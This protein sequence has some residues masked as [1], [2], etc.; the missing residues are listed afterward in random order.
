MMKSVR[1]LLASL[2]LALGAPSMPGAA[3]A[4][5][6]TQGGYEILIK[7]LTGTQFTLSVVPADTI[8]A[9]K[10]QITDRQGIPV[11]QQR[12]IF[13]GVQLEDQRTLSD[14]NVQKDATLYLVLRL[15]GG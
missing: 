8:A 11:E 1:V 14:Y 6:Q 7:T 10:Q 9:V 12:L 2:L 13:V 15:R 3:F 5:E 4:Q